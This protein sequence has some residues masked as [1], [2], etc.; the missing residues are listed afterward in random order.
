MNIMA[1]KFSVVK[2]IKILGE[3]P[4]KETS[5]YKYD[6]LK[7]IDKYILNR[8]S[9]INEATLEDLTHI[10]DDTI[11]CKWKIV[12]AHFKNICEFRNYCMN[13]YQDKVQVVYLHGNRVEVTGL[14][15]MA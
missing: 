7:D 10:I 15:I 12:S 4:K 1:I 9:C 11:K 6:E 5:E 13:K 14:D 8:L 3:L 2:I